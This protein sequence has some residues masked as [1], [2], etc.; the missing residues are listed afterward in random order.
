[1]SVL[2]TMPQ[3]LST[4]IELSHRHTFSL[5][6]MA[7]VLAAILAGI[8]IGWMVAK[9]LEKQNF[10]NLFVSPF[11]EP[12][13]PAGQASGEGFN[14]AVIAGWLVTMVVPGFALWLVA[15][16][17]GM[18]TAEAALWTVLTVVGVGVG[19]VLGG[20]IIG[21]LLAVVIIQ[22]F[23]PPSTGRDLMAP[24]DTAGA[25]I[26]SIGIA[27]GAAVYVSV[28]LVLLT[29]AAEFLGWKRI[30]NVLPGLCAFGTRVVSAVAILVIGRLGADWL[31]DRRPD[32]NADPAAQRWRLAILGLTVLWGMVAISGAEWGN[33]LLVAVFL[34]FAVLLTVGHDYIADITA[35]LYLKKHNILSAEID[36]KPITL[37][38]R[39]LL[40]SE[41]RQDKTV[42]RLGNRAIL[43]AILDRAPEAVLESGTTPADSESGRC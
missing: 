3:I 30:G 36:G 42:Y 9:A 26:R 2:G 14:P 1:M 8:R 41:W 21:R 33:V 37:A 29:F 6:H 28:Y 17:R 23:R 25:T 7:F 16:W 43:R 35:G 39:G 32:A 5:L 12:G 27:A 34:V 13:L 20:L 15:K 4:F 31:T 19:V 38:K 24:D 18:A 22:I 10:R 40:L 11:K